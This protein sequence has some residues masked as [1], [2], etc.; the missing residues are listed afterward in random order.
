MTLRRH[1]ALYS[2]IEIFLADV[3]LGDAEFLLHTEFNRQA[4][5]VPT[6]FSLHLEAL[7]RFVTAEHVLDGARHHVVNARMPVG[8]RGAFEKHIRGTALALCDAFVKEVSLVPLFEYFFVDGVEVHPRA[9]GE[10]FLS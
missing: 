8:R 1:W 5:R 7:H 10:L 6:G 2:S 4:V 9:L 3:F